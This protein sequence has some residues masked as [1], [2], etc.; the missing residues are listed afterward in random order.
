MRYTCIYTCGKVGVLRR[1]AE[2]GD[3]LILE[4]S[5]VTDVGSH[6]L[7]GCMER[8]RKKYRMEAEG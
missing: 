2:R 4:G 1:A 7:M 6:V 3:L 8:S 5:P